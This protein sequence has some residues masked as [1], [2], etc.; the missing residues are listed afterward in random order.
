[1]SYSKQQNIHQF[2]EDIEK[3]GGYVYTRDIYSSKI[4]HERN[5]EAILE[6]VDFEGKRVIDA[7]CGDGT[8]TQMLITRGKAKQVLAFDPCEKAL[9]FAKINN[10]IQNNINYINA[11]TDNFVLDSEEKYD[12]TLFRGMLHHIQYP[13]QAI[14][15]A[16]EWSDMVVILE[17]NGYSPILKIIEQFSK[18]HKE[19][20][21][22][23]YGFVK[24]NKWINEAGGKVIYHKRA[25]LV[26]CFCPDW[27]AKSLKFI[28]PLFE[29]TPVINALF[30]AVDIIVY[31][32]VKNLSK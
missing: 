6:S 1:M 7:G 19:H 29:K 26:P 32:S 22:C 10:N 14:E 9:E 18:Y 3:F 27:A 20:G 17:P 28:E 12:I 4:A 24:L 15:K 31:K 5:T 30:C 16:L 13:N 11:D 21:E 23:S 25:G 8:Y 2:G